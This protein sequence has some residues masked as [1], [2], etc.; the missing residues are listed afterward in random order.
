MIFPS[1]QLIRKVSLSSDRGGGRSLVSLEWDGAVSGAPRPRPIR[2][3]TRHTDTARR[4]PAA[5]LALT[6]VD[7]RMVL[8]IT[9]PF[10]LPAGSRRRAGAP[11][12]RRSATAEAAFQARC[13]GSV[14]FDP[15][16]DRQR[17]QQ[18][19]MTLEKA[20]FQHRPTSPASWTLT[21]DRSETRVQ[22]VLFAPRGAREVGEYDHLLWTYLA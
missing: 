17:R 10:P 13:G 2:R 15:E 16:S 9:P 1:K 7:P 3:A 11:S 12:T 22:F 19:Q 4:F 14:V 21:S 6:A 8:G 5:L 20:M 18:G